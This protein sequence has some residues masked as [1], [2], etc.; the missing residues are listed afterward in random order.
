MQ[1]SVAKAKATEE[2]RVRREKIATDTAAAS[3]AK[4]IDVPIM[5]PPI[6]IRV[7]ESPL[8]IAPA[9]EKITLKQGTA[10]DLTL[11][12]TRLFGFVGEIALEAAPAA[13]VNGL[14]I[15]P[16]T[17]PA[18]QPQGILKLTTTPQTPPGS[19]ELVIKAKVKFFE[20]EIVSERRVPVVIEAVAAEVPK[21]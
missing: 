19:Y 11:A 4:D 14:A 10:A 16:L 15:A 20:R 7:A 21:T 3:V 1:E 12:C 5:M 2:E 17:I 8:T 13:P 9:P 6:T 18:D